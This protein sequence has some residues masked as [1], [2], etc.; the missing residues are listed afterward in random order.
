MVLWVLAPAS[1]HAQNY[2]SA[3]PPAIKQ[4]TIAAWVVQLASD[5]STSQDGNAKRSTWRNTFGQERKTARWRKLGKR[6]IDADIV[7]LKRLKSLAD[8]RRL[9]PARTHRVIASRAALAKVSRSTELI[10]GEKVKPSPFT[11]E[12]FPAIAIRRRRGLRITAIRHITTQ[13]IGT[14]IAQTGSPPRHIALAARI[15]ATGRFI[16]VMTPIVDV[17]CTITD[18]DRSDCPTGKPPINQIHRWLRTFTDQKTP[19]IIATTTERPAQ[20]QSE[21]GEADKEAAKDASQK[22][23]AKSRCK[24]SQRPTIVAADKLPA[25]LVELGELKPSADRPCAAIAQLNYND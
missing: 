8:V 9:F 4:L 14:G 23:A 22:A 25:E 12:T 6:S 1:A 5:E 7:V 21:D 24:S 2:Q 17:T 3:S 13:T 10:A 19:I 18:Q 15:H 20:R 16:W 11:Y